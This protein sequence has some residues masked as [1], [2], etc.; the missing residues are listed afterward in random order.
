MCVR[1][2]RDRQ[3]IR[4]R[5]LPTPRLFVRPLWDALDSVKVIGGGVGPSALNET[6]FN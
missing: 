1:G 6:V 2:G 3:R 4:R 5:H